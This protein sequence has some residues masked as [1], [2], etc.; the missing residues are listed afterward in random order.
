MYPLAY[1][2]S[3][4]MCEGH[5]YW[6]FGINGVECYEGCPK[7]K[8]T[9][10]LFNCLLDSPEITSYLLQSYYPWL[11]YTMVPMFFPL[12]I[13]VPEVIFG[14]CVFVCSSSVTNFLCFPLSRSDDLSTSI[15]TWGRGRDRSGL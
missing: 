9:D 12:I 14:K 15:S 7:S 8:C 3:V 1:K 6:F 2:T 4:L 10:F 11:S 13:A 5:A